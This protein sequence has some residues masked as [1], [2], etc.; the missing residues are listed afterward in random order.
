[1]L[2]LLNEF[3]KSQLCFYENDNKFNLLIVNQL[4]YFCFTQINLLNFNSCWKFI[5]TFFL[6]KYYLVVN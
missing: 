4:D 3:V 6:T 5:E 1:M 2:R